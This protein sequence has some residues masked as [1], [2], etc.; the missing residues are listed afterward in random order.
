MSQEQIAL[1]AN[2]NRNTIGQIERGETSPS[3]DTVQKI[4]KALGMTFGELTDISD[5][6]L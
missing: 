6:N 4:A 3:V 1:C 2:L 5:I